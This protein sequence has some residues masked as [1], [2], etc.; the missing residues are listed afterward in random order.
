MAL[1][2]PAWCSKV[3]KGTVLY[4]QNRIAGAQ[5]KRELHK[6]KVIS[7]TPAQETYICTSVRNAAELSVAI[8]DWSATAGNT[9]PN[10]SPTWCSWSSSTICMTDEQRNPDLLVF[11]NIT[12]VLA[13]PQ[14]SNSS[15]LEYIVL[16]TIF[17]NFTTLQRVH[18]LKSLLNF[19]STLRWFFAGFTNFAIPCIAGH[20]CICPQV[21]AVTKAFLTL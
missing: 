21:N 14:D 18:S 5:R 13:L 12:V 7:L 3:N 11:G 1:D 8:L 6:S 16:F 19:W 10:P 9:A 15:N 17:I 2:W 4:K 20:K